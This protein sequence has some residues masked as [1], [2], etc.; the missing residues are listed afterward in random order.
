MVTGL[1]LF[2][3]VFRPFQSQYVLIGGS[4]CD[5]LGNRLG[6]S[7]RP[8]K[9]LDLVVC[10]E[11]V[12]PEFGAALWQFIRDGGYQP[13]FRKDE[14]RCLY[15][16][17]SPTEMDYPAMIELF[18]RIEMPRPPSDLR[19]IPLPLGE[20]NSSLSAILLDADCYAFIRG[21]CRDIDG[22]STLG[23][24]E[25]IVLKALAWMDLYRRRARGESVKEHDF[26]KHRQD[27]FRLLLFTIP[28][29]P[30][31]SLPPRLLNDMEDFLSTMAASPY[32]TSHLG[33]VEPYS[34]VLA[35]IRNLFDLSSPRPDSDS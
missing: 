33:I 28:G 23:P 9:D 24:A 6:V 11:A 19:I 8:T 16:F 22:V 12:T 4:A 13:Y 27:V 15:R 29:T 2:A 25:L 34:D 14:T 18:S 3:R 26:R 7:F 10:A 1:E 17:V 35:R 30:P 31:I 21:H 32:D 20:D 5:W